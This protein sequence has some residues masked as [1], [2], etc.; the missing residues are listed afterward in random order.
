MPESRDGFAMPFHRFAIRNIF[1]HQPEWAEMEFADAEFLREGITHRTNLASALRERF[2]RALAGDVEQ[3]RRAAEREVE[4]GTTLGER[5]FVKQV[6]V[7]AIAQLYFGYL[8]FLTAPERLESRIQGRV[9]REDFL[10]SATQRFLREI[11]PAENEVPAWIVLCR[12]GSNRPQHEALGINHHKPR[13]IESDILCLV[14]K[15][16]RAALRV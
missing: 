6:A 3:V 8:R 13:R 14:P 15:N 16:G 5:G 12:A 7:R 11:F 4:L 10:A 1:T 9:F 2:E